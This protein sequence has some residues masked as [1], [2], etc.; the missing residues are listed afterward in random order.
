[1]ICVACACCLLCGCRYVQRSVDVER[2]QLELAA[3]CEGEGGCSSSISELQLERFVL[4][5]VAR[6][7]LVA[8]FSPPLHADF[9]PFY[10][11]TAVRRFL[12]FLDPQRYVCCLSVSVHLAAFT[13]HYY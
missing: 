7:P 5:S 4:A 6:T 2:V 9:L 1:M 11:F 8:G 13:T 12:F 3:A 10:V